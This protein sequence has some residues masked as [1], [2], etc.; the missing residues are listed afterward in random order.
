M[1][2][3]EQRDHALATIAV[4]KYLGKIIKDAEDDAKTWLLENEMEPNSK[5]PAVVNGADIATVSRAKITEQTDV[6]VTDPVAFGEWLEDNGY[7]VK[8]K[9]VPAEYATAPT[10]VEQVL[11]ALETTSPGELPD[12]VTLVE[13]TSGGYISARQ[14]EK[15][16]ENLE[17]HVSTVREIVEQINTGRLAL[18]AGE[19]E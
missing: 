10:F 13:K 4:A 3:K 19:T 18:G 14:T 1:N 5:L 16:R 11:R 12:G 15:Q 9:R 7:E 2:H 6:K 8:W 17:Q